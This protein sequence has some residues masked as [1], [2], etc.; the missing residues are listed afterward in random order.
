MSPQLAAILITQIG[1]P[2]VE[3]LVKRIQQG[4]DMTPED[5][6]KLKEFKS[7]DE[8]YKAAT[9]LDAPTQE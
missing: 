7:A 6:A 3:Y 2:A 9:G 4:G 8:R 5:I 1:L